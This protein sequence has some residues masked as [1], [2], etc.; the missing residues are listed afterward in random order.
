MSNCGKLRSP[1][2]W[3]GDSFIGFNWTIFW[4]FRVV[5]LLFASIKSSSSGF[6]VKVSQF[7]SNGRLCILETSVWSLRDLHSNLIICHLLIWLKLLFVHD[8]DDEIVSNSRCKK[9]LSTNKTEKGEWTW[10]WSYYKSGHKV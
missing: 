7:V 8:D 3:T 9:N 6:L 4:H 10:I 2:G 1:A 5:V